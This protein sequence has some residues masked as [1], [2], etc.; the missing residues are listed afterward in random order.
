VLIL[1]PVLIVAA[2]MGYGV[3][4]ALISSFQD[5]NVMSV[6]QGFVGLANYLELFR[7]ARFLNSLVRTLILAAGTVAL[8]MVVSLSA[9]LLLSRV[10]ALRKSLNALALVPWLVSAV[11][12]A[13]MFRF[14]FV[15]TA[16][17]ANNVLQR[18]GLQPVWWFTSPALTTMILIVAVTWY[19]APLSTIVL[20]GGLT[21][22]DQYL[23]ESAQLDG[24][25]KP[26]MFVS[27]TLPLIRPMMRVSLIWLTF[28]SFNQF[29]VV[30]PA[31][32][33]GPGRS[34][35][36]MALLM[37][38]LAFDS[39]DFSAAYA[40]TILLMAVNILAGLAYTVLFR[41]R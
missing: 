2:L 29:D 1:P 27:I 40:V 41:E 6:S 10:V 7:D 12:V 32:G 38:R 25:S 8:G 20:V 23:Y 36:V 28:A 14:M 17:L 4:V 3:T 33:G 24:A 31:T 11:A 16:G 35:E 26:R 9:A 30:L 18:L 13:M 19:I 15:G 34:T 21:T 37:Y 39:F 5:L 22:I